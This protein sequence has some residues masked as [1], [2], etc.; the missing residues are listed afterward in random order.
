MAKLHEGKKKKSDD[1]CHY[2]SPCMLACMLQGEVTSFC[3]VLVI[4]S[5]DGEKGSVSISFQFEH[6]KNE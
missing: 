1:L 3:V 4:N 2:K 5:T 6:V